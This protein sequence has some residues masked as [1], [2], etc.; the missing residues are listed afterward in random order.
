MTTPRSLE[1][2]LADRMRKTLRARGISVQEMADY[3]GVARNTL[4]TWI[5]GHIEPSQRT[6]MAWAERTGVRVEW[7]MDGTE[8]AAAKVPVPPHPGGG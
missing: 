5:N 3:L 7:L 2:T 1:W 8:P 6:V 4:S